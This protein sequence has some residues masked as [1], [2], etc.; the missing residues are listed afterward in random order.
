MELTTQN[1]LQLDL[2]SPTHFNKSHYSF[3]FIQFIV[4]WEFL[5]RPTQN[6]NTQRMIRRV[7]HIEFSA[8]E[9]L[10]V[11]ACEMYNERAYQIVVD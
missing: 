6:A 10:E 3:A 5:R 11:L 1:M 4:E 7:E 2:N 9:L 8:F